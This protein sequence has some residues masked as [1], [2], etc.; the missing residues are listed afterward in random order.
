MIPMTPSKVY[1]TDFRTTIGVSLTAKLQ[2]LC[3]A[4]GIADTMPDVPTPD[5]AFLE[6]RAAILRRNL[7]MPIQ[8]MS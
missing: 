5:K 2:K 6:S 1:F 7:C 3:R 4:A 8:I